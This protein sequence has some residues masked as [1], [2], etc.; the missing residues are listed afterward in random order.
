M[1]RREILSIAG[2]CLTVAALRA[3]AP[4]D[5]TLRIS[6]VT[7]ELSPGRFIKTTGYNGQTPGPLLRMKEGK[8]VTVDV[9][10]DTKEH[11]IVHWHG[12]HIPPEVDGAHEEG[13]PPV[14]AGDS[15]RYVFTPAPAGTRWYHSHG[16]AGRNLHKTTYSGQFGMAIVDAASDP[17]P[18]DLEIPILLHEWEPYFDEDMDVAY[19]LYSVNGKMLGAGEPVRV[20]QSQRVLF[21]ILNASATLTH[22]LA[23]TGH[24]F[25]VIALDGNSVASPRS[26]PFLELGPA[27]RVDAIVTMDRPG[28]WVLGETRDAHRNAGLGIVIEYAGQRGAPRWASPEQFA[29]DYALFG[30]SGKSPKPDGTFSL[31]IKAGSGHKWT[32]NGKSFPHTVPMIVKA[33]RRYRIAFD[34][35]SSEA[36]PMHV[37]RH[38]FEITNFAGKPMSGVLKDTVMVPA[39]RTAEVELIASQPG[40][41]LI[42]CHQQYHMDFGFMLMMQYSETG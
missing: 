16:H 11:E 36:H 21:R 41:T 10:N 4:A 8:S 23:L 13:T 35:Q 17:A 15:H 22:R 12:F 33:G 1:T 3:E 30:G 14:M 24:S 39:W 31:T 19:K 40:A 25:K 38:N 7:L 6:D 42:H 28:I 5:V 34:N 9:L 32:I 29:W 18:Y 26:V 37:H 20:R 2:G 27:E